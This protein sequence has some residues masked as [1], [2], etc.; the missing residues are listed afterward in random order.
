M[1]MHCMD[2]VVECRR[3]LSVLW[4]YRGFGSREDGM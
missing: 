2:G 4:G 1:A 3:G